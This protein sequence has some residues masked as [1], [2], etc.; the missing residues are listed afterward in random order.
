[1]RS[2]S[3]S[4]TVYSVSNLETTPFVSKI[5]TM[6]KHKTIHS[7]ESLLL[8]TWLNQKREEQDVSI[9]Q[10]ADRLQWSSSIVG[11]ILAGDRRLDVVEYVQ[12]CA[13]LGVNPSEG[14][15]VIKVPSR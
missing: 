8:R 9:R 15:A 7:S 6:S 4:E 14:L 12:I 1:M 10:L 3:I 11:K 13:A 2:V 5:E